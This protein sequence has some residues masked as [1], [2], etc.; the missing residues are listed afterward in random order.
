[1][2][3]LADVLRNLEMRIPGT[4]TH[5]TMVDA[6]NTALSEIGKV[7][8]VDD[9]MVV[10]PN[11]MEFELPTGVNNVVRVQVSV[12]STNEYFTTVFNW[13]EVGGYIY[14]PGQLGYTAGNTI[15]VY[16]NEIHEI[17]DDDADEIA[18]GIPMPLIC[19]IAAYRYALLNYQNLSNLGVKDKDILNMLMTE[20]H[21]AKLNHRVKK[22]KRDPILGSER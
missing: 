16:Y 8:R 9:T 6:V 15:R 13:R 1:M 5:E 17:V 12:D 21:E 19:A 3:T 7:T 10:V 18:E 2:T 4:A 22:M 20:A 11:Q 14:F